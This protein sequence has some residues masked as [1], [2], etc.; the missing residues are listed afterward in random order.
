V[1]DLWI[2]RSTIYLDKTAKDLYFVGDINQMANPAL[3]I[4]LV[5]KLAMSVK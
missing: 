5:M 1:A 2:W 4:R 3:P